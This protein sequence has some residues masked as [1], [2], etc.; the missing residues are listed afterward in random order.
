MKVTGGEYPASSK[1]QI[2]AKLVMALQ[3]LFVLS[4]WFGE[5]MFSLIGQP[6]PQALSEI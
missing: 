5:K 1:N 2:L 3:A 6:V 4:I